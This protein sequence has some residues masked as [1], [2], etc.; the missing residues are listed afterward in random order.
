VLLALTNYA[1]HVGL[2]PEVALNRANNRF[3]DRFNFVENQVVATGRP[4]AEF[5]LRDPTT[6]GREPKKRKKVKKLREN[7]CILAF[8]MIIYPEYRTVRLV[9]K[10]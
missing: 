10:N 6:F 7:A 3:K 5:A 2:E 4:W 1:R 9:Q 8:F